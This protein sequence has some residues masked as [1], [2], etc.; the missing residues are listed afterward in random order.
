MLWA[1]TKSKSINWLESLNRPGTHTWLLP[2]KI[3]SLESFCW[4]V[5]QGFLSQLIMCQIIWGDILVIEMRFCCEGR[6]SLL[7][8]KCQSSPDCL[9][10]HHN[11]LTIKK[12]IFCWWNVTSN[13]CLCETNDLMTS[14]QTNKS[15]SICIIYVKL[16]NY[17][18]RSGHQQ[19]TRPR[20]LDGEIVKYFCKMILLFTVDIQMNLL[21][22]NCLIFSQLTTTLRTWDFTT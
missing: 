8:E 15:P 1:N 9:T 7:R 20:H 18:H 22:R 3:F 13:C 6:P 16:G 2:G 12:T 17:Q 14:L 21:V 19:P 4:G 5:T 10:P 11:T